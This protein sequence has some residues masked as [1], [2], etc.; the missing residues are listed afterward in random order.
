MTTDSTSKMLALAIL[1]TLDRFGTLSGRVL[2]GHVQEAVPQFSPNEYAD[3]LQHLLTLELVKQID[4]GHAFLHSLT[5]DGI[6]VLEK[7]RA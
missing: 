6:I 5:N 4:A 1:K 7:H 2:Y 3:A